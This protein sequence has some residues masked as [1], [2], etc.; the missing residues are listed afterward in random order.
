[1]WMPGPTHREATLVVERD[2]LCTEEAQE[3]CEGV[4]VSPERIKR[5]LGELPKLEADPKMAWMSSGM[6]KQRRAAVEL[7]MNGLPG[8]RQ[9][10]GRTSGY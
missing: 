4:H 1:V 8:K 5:G 2:H 3:G 7:S 9:I 10:G 6:A